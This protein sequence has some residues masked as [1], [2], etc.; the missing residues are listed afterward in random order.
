MKDY[1]YFQKGITKVATDSSTLVSSSKYLNNPRLRD[2]MMTHFL[3]RNGKDQPIPPDTT[4]GLVQALEEIRDLPHVLKLIDREKTLNPKFAAWLEERHLCR[5][6]KADFAKFKPNTMGGLYYKYLVEYGFELNLGRGENLPAPSSDLEFIFL[7]FGQIHD[8]EHLIT[9]GQFN[10]LGELL[11]YFV[12]LS[13]THQHMSAE[14][15]QFFTEIYIFGGT[16][17]VMR[18][19]LHYPTA[20]L[21]VM[22]LMRRGIAIGLASESILMARYED[23]LELEIP[24][25]RELLGIRNATDMDTAHDDSV[26]IE[27]REPTLEELTIIGRKDLAKI[28]I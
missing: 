26:F 16:R 11:P 8:Y 27:G 15:A 5:R 9:G 22:D 4:L 2:W 10:S 17:M 19:A 28:R 13:N 7:R 3:R 1:S 25:A 21:T 12:R 20:W 14:L 6:T 18:T 23:A 24:A